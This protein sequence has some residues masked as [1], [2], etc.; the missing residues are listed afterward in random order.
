MFEPF[1]EIAFANL[2]VEAD[3]FALHPIGQVRGALLQ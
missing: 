2:F 1:S 3:V